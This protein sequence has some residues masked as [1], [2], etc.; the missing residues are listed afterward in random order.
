MKSFLL[1]L[2]AFFTTQISS[3]TTKPVV[4]DNSGEV[5][6][7]T[8]IRPD[9][10]MPR[11]FEEPPKVI[12]VSN[13]VKLNTV[14]LIGGFQT[15]PRDGGR[16]VI[17]IASML[18]VEPQVFRDVFSGVR[19]SQD[20]QPT[21]EEAR[22]NKKVLLDGL[23]KYGITNEK[24]DQVSN[25]YRYMG[26]KGQTWPQ[27]KAIVTVEIKGN[28]SV[29]TIVDAGVG[30]TTNPTFS[31]TINGIVYKGYGKIM[32]TQDFTTNGSIKEL[33]FY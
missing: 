8:S 16:P 31:I 33:V 25:Y 29:A 6:M 22:A 17:L 14:T 23:G 26:S 20:G 19:P 15:D 28:K 9:Q 1:F 21:D 13:E 27:R 24:L 4:V 12:Q 18:G 32:C 10:K 30:Y 11:K 2:T 7:E 5:R 3:T